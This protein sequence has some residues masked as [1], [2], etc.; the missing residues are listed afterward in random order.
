M[1][2]PNNTPPKK[3][4]PKPVGDAAMT[5]TERQRRRREQLRATGG[6]GFLLELEGLH[7][8]Y[9]EALAQSQG[10]STAAALR[11]LVD[12]A[13]SRYVG[14]MRRSERMA[15]NGASD[16]ACAQFIRD[17]LYPELPPMP[18]EAAEK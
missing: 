17:H 10:M 8:Q 18:P 14:V 15:E 6:K 2:D 11:L 13:L 9:V 7:L 4:G 3:R 16:E 12:N 5:N 1:T